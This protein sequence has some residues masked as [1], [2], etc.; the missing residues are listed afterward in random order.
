MMAV[1]LGCAVG[2]TL[3]INFQILPENV[4]WISVTM[5]AADLTKIFL[6]LGSQLLLLQLLPYADKPSNKILFSL[7]L[8][9]FFNNATW[10]GTY[11]FL[12]S[13]CSRLISDKII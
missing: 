11:F 6:S 1:M 5:I 3:R 12:V 2:H 7:N 8:P 13:L 9:L 4:T 10:R